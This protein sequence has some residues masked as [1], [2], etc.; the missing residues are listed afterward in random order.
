MHVMGMAAGRGWWR[1]GAARLENMVAVVGVM[2]NIKCDDSGDGDCGDCGS[3]ADYVCAYGHGIDAGAYGGGCGVMIR[4]RR[5]MAIALALFP[6]S[7]YKKSHGQ[8]TPLFSYSL[9]HAH[10]RHSMHPRTWDGPSCHG[11]VWDFGPGVLRRGNFTI[12]LAFLC[13]LIEHPGDLG[14][15]ARASDGSMS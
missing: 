13:V 4:I 12:Q 14:K 10:C 11:T 6:Q 1:C 8:I 2:T 5:M 7:R 3:D 9:S 15:D